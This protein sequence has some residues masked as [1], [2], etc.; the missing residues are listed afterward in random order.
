MYIQNKS[1]CKKIL[2][3]KWIIL[4]SAKTDYFVFYHAINSYTF[5]YIVLYISLSFCLCALHLVATICV[6]MLSVVPTKYEKKF[7]Y[8][9][10]LLNFL[11]GITHLPF[12]ELS[13]IIFTDI[14][15]R[16]WRWSVNSIESGQTAWKCRLA[17]LY[18]GSKG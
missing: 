9:L 10:N 14:K 4:M 18:T 8:T 16:N 17:W 13:I 2:D 12:L 6:I 1:M 3:C 15:M 11:K 7:W 5:P